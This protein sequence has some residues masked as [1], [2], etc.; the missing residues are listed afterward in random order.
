V[1]TA[2][3]ASAAPT[4]IGTGVILATTNTATAGAGSLNLIG[5][6]TQSGATLTTGVGATSALIKTGQGALFLGADNSAGFSGLLVIQGGTVILNNAK[7]LS[8]GTTGTIVANNGADDVGQGRLLPTTSVDQYA[9]TLGKWFGLSDS[10]L[11]EVL[12]NLVNFNAS[13]RTLGFV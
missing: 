10:Q 2:T 3:A 11:L 12:P 9:A 6:V 8:T 7:A 4:T 5:A 13:Q 1:A